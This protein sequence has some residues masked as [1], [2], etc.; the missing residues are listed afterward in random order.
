MEKVVQIREKILVSRLLSPDNRR[1]ERETWSRN[2][3]MCPNQ[4]FS[5]P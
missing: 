4:G 2:A 1:K 3:T 5:D